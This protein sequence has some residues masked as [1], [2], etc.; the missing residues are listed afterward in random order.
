MKMWSIILSVTLLGVFSCKPEEPPVAPPDEPESPVEVIWSV[1]KHPDTLVSFSSGMLKYQDLIFASAEPYGS[2]LPSVMK[3]VNEE[4]EI[5]WDSEVL[6][7]I[8]PGLNVNDYHGSFVHNGIMV[9]LCNNRPEALNFFSGS[10]LWEWSSSAAGGTTLTRYGDKVFCTERFSG[11]FPYD[12][13]RILMIDIL[14]GTGKEVF[15]VGVD[16]GQKPSL[17]SPETALSPAGDT[18]LWFQNRTWNFDATSDWG[19]IDLY[20]FNL[21]A[22]T[23]VWQLIDI[24]PF[25]ISCVGKPLYADGR[26]YFRAN[27]IIQCY[28]AW[29]GEEI[30]S[31]TFPEDSGALTLGNTLLEDGKLIVKSGF[32]GIHAFDPI[33]GELLWERYDAGT[34]STHMTYFDGN[35]YYGSYNGDLFCVRVADGEILWKYRS[36]FDGIPPYYETEFNNNVVIDPETRRLYT[37]DY[38][39]LHCLQ[40]KD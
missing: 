18:L 10:L 28:N 34:T 2:P 20:C 37:T 29:T 31:H 22:D 33:T 11:S 7:G 26:L 6:G 30:W 25:G 14:T 8:C 39:Y 4:G 38:Y 19:R 40:L 27:Q 24:D 1:A 17:Y 35:V 13:S 23:L 32:G 16:N 5:V 12:S 36:P 3:V 15:R 9:Y 21:T